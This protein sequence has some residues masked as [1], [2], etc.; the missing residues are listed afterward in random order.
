MDLLSACESLASNVLEFN[1]TSASDLQIS[2]ADIEHWRCLFKLTRAEAIEEI[3]NWRLDFGRDSLSQSAWD[4]IKDSDFASGFS[5]ESYEFSLAHGRK[6]ERGNATKTDDNGMYLLRIHDTLPSLHTIQQLLNTDRLEVVSGVDDD[7]NSVKF[8]YMTSQMKNL[9]QS[10]LV[11]SDSVHFRPS[12]IRVSIATKKL[13]D[14]SRY[15]TL[16]IESTLPQYRAETSTEYFRP[17]QNEYPVPYFFYG[18]L[19]DRAV[20]AR[21]IG[22][23]DEGSIEYE[24][25]MVSGAALSTW[26]NK[27]LGLVNSFQHDQVEGKVYWVKSREEEEA[28]RIY[29]TAK[30]EVVRCKI[31]LESG[32]N[33]CMGLTFRLC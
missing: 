32:I 21:V 17:A 12:F 30:Y 27:Y 1:A 4:L 13:S 11:L 20:L 28:L 3:S 8:C 2:D 14:I 24:S 15:P 23:S 6:F 18:T 22:V 31:N 16:G 19:A 9:L 25:A 26:A 29:E 10:N 33:T 5:K 7:G